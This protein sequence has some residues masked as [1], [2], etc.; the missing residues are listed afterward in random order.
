M[1][2]LV[3][4]TTGWA[5]DSP[6]PT[7]E[8]TSLDGEPYYRI[9]NY[10]RLPSFLMNI[11]SDGD[12][13]M[14]ITSSG[15]LTAGR[16]DAD[17]SLFA[18]ETV[19]KLHDG[20]THTGPITA[21]RVC[22]NGRPEVLWRPFSERSENQF[23]IERHLYK[24]V[25][26]N[27]LAF[28]EINQDVELGFRYRW[29]GSDDL[30]LVRTATLTNYGSQD[31]AV[32]LLDGL[33]NVLPYGVS[34][35]LQQQSSCLVDAYKR[36][37]YDPGTLLG[38]FALTSGIV[39]R[40][41]PAEVLRANIVWCRGLPAA[42]VC[43]SSA[44]VRAFLRGE[45]IP[46]ATVLTG[47]RGNYLALSTLE[48]KAGGQAK[49]HVVADVG[50]SHVQ[51]AALRRRLA[52]REDL[53]RDIEDSLRRASL[54]LLQNVASADGVQLTGSELDTAHHFAN[55]L[56]NNMRGG[57]FAKNYDIPTRDFAAFLRT[58]NCALADRYTD[59][60]SALPDEMPLRA[61]RA[62][63]ESTRSGDLQRLVLE[64][65]PLWFGR[66][67]GD[68]SRP[69]N[70][71]TIRVRNPDGSRALHYEG[72]W[73]D[74]F[75]NWEALSSS[76][77]RFLPNIIAK[78]VN[79]S[80][81]DGFNPYRIMR[82]G[83]DWEVVDSDDPWS[84]IGYWGDHQIVYL[85]K[86]LEALQR[87]APG[88]LEELLTREIF[89]YADVPYRIAPYE[90]IV[91]DPHATI[92]YDR[93]TAARVADRVRDL[94]AD[95]TLVHD[96]H[97][98]IH[99][100]GLLEKLLVPALSKLSNLVPDA[101]I[102]MNT[103]RPEWNDANNALAGYGVSMV[104]LSYLRRYL[105]FLATL[106]DRM[107][108]AEV[109][110]STEV[111][112]WCRGLSSFLRAEHGL[113][114]QRTVADSDRRR[115]LDGLGQT[116]AV[117]RRQVYSSGFSGKGPIAAPDVA[118]FC[119]VALEFL[120]HAIHANRREDGLYH[121]YN[122][123]EILPGGAEAKVRPLDEMLEGQVAVLS[124]GVVDAHEAVA[125]LAALF[126]SRLYRQDQ[127]SFLLYPERELPGFLD[128][129]VV[130]EHRLSGVSLLRNLLDAG[131]TSVVER[132]AFGACRFQ[133]D[134]R[135]AIDLDAALDR[136][137]ERSAWAEQVARDR[138]AVH[139]IFEAVFDH[140]SF[141]GRSGT[142]YGYEGLGS[143]YWHMVSKLL[144]A[145]QEITI[146]SVLEELPASVVESLMKA[147]YRIRGGLGFEKSVAEFGAFP[148]DP[149]SHTPAHG[150][151]Q[152]PGMTGQ[153]KEQILTRFGE[154]GVCVESGRLRFCPILLRRS[155]F[156]SRPG[157][158]DF[159]DLEATPV[160]VDVP[161]GAL[162]FSICQV[163]V[164]YRLSHEA[165]IRITETGGAWVSHTGDRVDAEQS[166][167]IFDRLGTI[168]Q[169]EVGVSERSL[170]PF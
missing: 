25:I 116:F 104:T 60:L 158:A 113:L 61:L 49:W 37:E 130:P 17:G 166:R 41:E 94:G 86:F 44:A 66:R 35:T 126:Q 170:C 39:D 33:R 84:Y 59:F 103:Q 89:C 64:Y 5:P 75:Q 105:R 165:W 69:W 148:M 139:D 18:Y 15:G 22:R 54:S 34:L 82:E 137:A 31:V 156:R 101:G 26:G 8:F 88:E 9:S 141:T 164:V 118:K 7:G 52:T 48:L 125:L 128:R 45:A 129:N 74:I 97:G 67:H 96:R 133:A 146:R 47:R 161:A 155:E 106:L 28:E 10:Q 160:S 30:G 12:L 38:I 27:R 65:L 76:F 6:P 43:L 29:S 145:V 79:A 147:Y 162:A 159:Y 2:S 168:A 70:R 143:V 151:A 120:D 80:T 68:P 36:S 46:R 99:H 131:E 121:A 71:F 93:E 85:L 56:F 19:D 114:A 50:R 119:S 167:A 95:G 51:I 169:I 152:Q 102:W 140:K 91:R 20:H 135:N 132:D 107:G 142:M 154:L 117:Y 23:R 11:P 100:V 13:W 81:M 73:R 77:P 53:D 109:S 55:V 108:N 3:H 127:R 87:F 157:T 21:I 83:I 57:V 14:F 111:V 98:R 92:V 110:M 24:N 112:A 72:N 4:M 153:V 149:Y 150:G 138:H 115:L 63:A 124:S 16:V 134:F 58:R 123:L 163:P 42:D 32:V 62:A 136:L 144:L 90:E 78:F 122:L 40:A 1:E